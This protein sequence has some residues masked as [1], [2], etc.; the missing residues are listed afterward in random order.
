VDKAAGVACRFLRAAG[1]PPG[2]AVYSTRPT[3]CRDFYCTWRYGVG[4][5]GDRPDRSEVVLDV[6][7]PALAGVPFL[8]ARGPGVRGGAMAFLARV[9][10]QHVVVLEGLGGGGGGG[11]GSLL[12]VRDDKQIAIGPE[13]SL[14]AFTRA[15][16]ARGVEVVV[17]K[18]SDIALDSTLAEV[19]GADTLR[20]GGRS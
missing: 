20:N 17:E 14:A 1:N 13:A 6:G 8:V 16:T 12:A 10:K 9:A 2:C 7:R 11:L 4:E 15:L 5:D 19:E 3:Q 18:R